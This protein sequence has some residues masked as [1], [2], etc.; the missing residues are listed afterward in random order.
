MCYNNQ[1]L[2]SIY[3]YNDRL[4]YI[5]CL[6]LSGQIFLTYSMIIEKKK[7]IQK[8]L[9]NCRFFLNRGFK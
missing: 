5:G 1:F 9:K 8:I 4:I 6:N 7:I 2:V 3:I